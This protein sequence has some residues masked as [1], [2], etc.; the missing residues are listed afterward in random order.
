M[1]YNLEKHG[2]AVAKRAPDSA[3]KTGSS[4][5]DQALGVG[6]FPRGRII[7]IFGGPSTGKT[8][9]ALVAGA[10][11]QRNGG[12]VAYID[13]EHKLDLAW[14]QVNGLN[15]NSGLVLQGTEGHGVIRSVLE[16]TQ[17]G[18]FALIVVDTLS[19]LVPDEE[20]DL[21]PRDYRAELNQ[22]LAQ[23][24]PRIAAAAAK[25]NTCIL[26]LNQVRKNDAMFGREKISAGGDIVDHY[27]SIR[28]ELHRTTARKNGDTVVGFGVK[29]TVL[30]SCV[31]PPFRQAEWTINFEHGIV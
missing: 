11:A 7:E 20:L 25:T 1:T 24:L 10:N 21:N 4:A 23:A 9:L 27:S 31:A 5:L 2:I 18:R 14:A 3:I 6:G 28:L 26:L 15:G 22:L 12:A 13:S 17:S 30:K 8:T 29:A 19:A 16:F